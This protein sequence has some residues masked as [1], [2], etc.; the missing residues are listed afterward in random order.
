MIELTLPTMT[1]GHCVKTVTETVQRVDAAARVAIDLP[2]H[3]VR[4]ESA[5][6][7]EAFTAALAEEGF[8]AA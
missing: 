1:C 2:M 8:E 3:A 5:R 6:P 7:A 4:I